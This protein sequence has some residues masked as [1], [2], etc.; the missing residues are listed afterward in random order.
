MATVTGRPVD[1]IMQSFVDQPGAPVVSVRTTCTGTTTEIALRRSASSARPAP[2]APPQTWTL[3]VCFKANDGQPRCE[4]IDAP[5][6]T[7]S[8]PGCDNVFA[9]ADSRGYYFTEYTPDAVRALARRDAALKPVER[10][11]LLGDE[12]WMVRA[13]GTTSASTWI[14]RRRSP[15]TRRRR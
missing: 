5:E 9:N 15:P 3:P 2:A 4:V 13:G 14:S 10:L 7:V 6:Q 12:W 8:A 1:R 11:G